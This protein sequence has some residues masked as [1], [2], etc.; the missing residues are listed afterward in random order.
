MQK[1]YNLTCK[2][3]DFQNKCFVYPAIEPDHALFGWPDNQ[4]FRI[5]PQNDENKAPKVL[6]LMDWMARNEMIRD[7]DKNRIKT[8]D[9]NYYANNKWDHSVAIIFGFDYP[10]SPL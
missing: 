5:W 3:L 8:I 1:L 4:Q 7:E 2:V 9:I 10:A 6:R